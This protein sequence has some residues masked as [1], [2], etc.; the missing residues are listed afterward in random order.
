MNFE[1][2]LAKLIELEDTFFIVIN[3]IPEINQHIDVFGN[4]V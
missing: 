2:G 1:K 3:S 4:L